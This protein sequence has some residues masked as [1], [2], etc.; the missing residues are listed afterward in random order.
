[1]LKCFEHEENDK[2]R[3]H[4]LVMNRVNNKSETE[5]WET[6]GHPIADKL[7]SDLMIKWTRRAKAWGVDF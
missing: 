4:K 2:L 1:M 5:E 6:S 7:L 3:F